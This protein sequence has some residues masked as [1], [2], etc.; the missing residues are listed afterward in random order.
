MASVCWWFRC[1]L[2][3]DES[4]ALEPNPQSLLFPLSWIVRLNKTHF[5]QNGKTNWSLVLHV[6]WAMGDSHL[7]YEIS[8]CLPLANKQNKEGPLLERSIL[9][10]DILIYLT[11]LDLGSST[12]QRILDWIGEKKSWVW[13]PEGKILRTFSCKVSRCRQGVQRPGMEIPQYH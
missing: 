7:G 6:S 12:V 3:T 4:Q 8:C 13:N 9:F 5:D 10:C 1:L 2:T 11:I